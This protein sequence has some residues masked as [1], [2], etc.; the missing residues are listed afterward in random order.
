MRRYETDGW[1]VTAGWLAVLPAGQEILAEKITRQPV[2]V[3]FPVHGDPEEDHVY[4]QVA[5]GYLAVRQDR[6]SQAPE[7]LVKR[8]SR[9]PLVFPRLSIARMTA[10]EMLEEP[11]YWAP[12]LE[13]GKE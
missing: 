1:Q 2:V 9:Q 11:Y 8:W 7:V 4:R 12:L 3:S 10:A 6:Q 13:E 5:A